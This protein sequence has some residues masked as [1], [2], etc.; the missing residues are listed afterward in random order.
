MSEY[1]NL[2]ILNK[3]DESTSYCSDLWDTFNQENL[4]R[5]PHVISF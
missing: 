2:D 5:N 4:R 3:N 1:F